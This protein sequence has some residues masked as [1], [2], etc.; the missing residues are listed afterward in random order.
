MCECNGLAS[1]LRDFDYTVSYW[2]LEVLVNAKKMKI[3]K[4]E[5]NEN[6]KMRTK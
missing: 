3:E 4:C 2:S 6:K 1:S 5:N